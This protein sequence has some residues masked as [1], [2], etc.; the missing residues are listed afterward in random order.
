M[1]LHNI[2]FVKMAVSFSLDFVSVV[3]NIKKK[4]GEVHTIT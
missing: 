1:S 3:L 2:V 4:K